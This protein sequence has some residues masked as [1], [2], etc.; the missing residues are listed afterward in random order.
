MCERSLTLSN[1]SKSEVCGKLPCV[2]TGTSPAKPLLEGRP[3][4]LHSGRSAGLSGPLRHCP[5]RGHCSAFPPRCSAAHGRAAKTPCF[6]VARLSSQSCHPTAYRVTPSSL[7][8]PG[9]SPGTLSDGAGVAWH[10]TRKFTGPHGWPTS[11]PLAA[12]RRH[13]ASPFWPALASSTLY[14]PD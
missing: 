3:G 14:S 9:S 10:A 6:A 7:T 8:A 4:V 13:R 2:M 5:L 1:A 11:W 12:G